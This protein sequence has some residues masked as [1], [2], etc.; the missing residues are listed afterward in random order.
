M[1]ACSPARHAGAAAAASAS[2]AP[3]LSCETRT[4]DVDG[5]QVLV[6][7][8]ADASLASAR[9]LSATDLAAAGKAVAQVTREFGPMRTDT[10]VVER[11]NKWGLTTLTDPCGRPLP[12][13]T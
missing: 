12:A 10:R 9:V 5:A 13:H 3:L 8:N 1:A 2:P 4:V 11:P 6:T 7:S